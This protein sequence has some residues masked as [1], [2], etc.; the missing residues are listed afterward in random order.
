MKCVCGNTQC[1]VCSQNVQDYSHFGDD[2]CPL[3]NDT[4]ERLRTEVAT[5]Q[6]RA[7]RDFNDTDTEGSEIVE[8]P[9]LEGRRRQMTPPPPKDQQDGLWPW[10]QPDPDLQGSQQREVEYFTELE[11]ILGIMSFRKTRG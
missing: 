3:F 5:A 10:E 4:A 2:K 1:F 9:K 8:P 7:I 6:E 11:G